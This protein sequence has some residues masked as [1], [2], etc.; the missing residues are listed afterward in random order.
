MTVRGN[1]GFTLVE[2]LVVVAIAGIVLAVAAVNL[3]PSDEEVARRE[4]ALL[5]LDIE[6]A[7]DDAWFGGRPTGLTL[8]EG[9]V[10]VLRL[11]S[12]RSWSPVP[13]RERRLPEA[14]RVA[15]LAIDGR[16]VDPREVLVF[17]PDGLGVP[18][19]VALTVRGLPKAIE[20][21]AAGAVR[22]APR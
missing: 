17:L 3:F 16:E 19:R 22:V 2:I 6:A 15:S 12:D 20:G 11:A 7:R 5:A 13:G 4:T 1:A 10:R 14:L 8:A 18:F 9:R 21:D